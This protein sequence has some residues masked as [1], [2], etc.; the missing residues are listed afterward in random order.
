[1]DK[2]KLIPRIIEPTEYIM[3]VDCVGKSSFSTIT[4]AKK[5]KGNIVI[6]GGVVETPYSELLRKVNELVG[7]RTFVEKEVRDE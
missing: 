1:M 2:F 5:L 4:I 3:G 6:V 7:V